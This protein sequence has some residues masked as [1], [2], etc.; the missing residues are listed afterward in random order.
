MPRLDERCERGSRVDRESLQTHMTDPMDSDRGPH[1][2]QHHGGQ[3]YSE[4]PVLDDQTTAGILHS[5]TYGRG[6]PGEETGAGVARTMV[7]AY[8]KWLQYINYEQRNAIMHV[9]AA[10]HALGIRILKAMRRWRGEAEEASKLIRLAQYAHLRRWG[11]RASLRRW[12][13]DAQK[14]K[15]RARAVAALAER[16]RTVPRMPRVRTRASAMTPI[17]SPV[18][19]GL[20][21][22]VD[23][24]GERVDES[25]TQRNLVEENVA[26]KVKQMRIEMEGRL[27]IAESSMR[28]STGRTIK[29]AVDKCEKLVGSTE[30]RSSFESRLEQVMQRIEAIEEAVQN[31]RNGVRKSRRSRSKSPSRSRSSSREASASE[32]SAG[33]V[34]TPSTSGMRTVRRVRI[35]TGALPVRDDDASSI[36]SATSSRAAASA[37]GLKDLSGSEIEQYKCDMTAK[38]IDERLV[39]FEDDMRQRHPLLDELLECTS[40]EYED[41]MIDPER[42]DLR[43]V[44][45]WLGRTCRQLVKQGGDDAAVFKC[46]E[47]QVRESDR[48][49]YYSGKRTLARMVD[50]HSLTSTKKVLAHEQMLKDKVYLDAS[51]NEMTAKR[52]CAAICDDWR[53]LPLTKRSTDKHALVRLLISKI[54]ASIREG[55]EK[56]LRE[57]LETELEE[58]EMKERWEGH[59]ERTSGKGLRWRGGAGTGRGRGRVAT[60]DVGAA[61]YTRDQLIELIVSRV[62]RKDGG[63]NVNFANGQK[64]CFNCGSKQCNLGM[65]KCDQLGKCRIKGCPCVRSKPCPCDMDQL[66]PRE[67]IESGEPGRSVTPHVYNKIERKWKAKHPSTPKGGA[68]PMSATSDEANKSTPAGAPA[69]ATSA[70]GIVGVTSSLVG[71][72]VCCVR[73]QK[74]QGVQAEREAEGQSVL[75]VSAPVFDPR[76]S[77]RSPVSVMAP[78]EAAREFAMRMSSVCDGAVVQLSSGESL[79]AE[80]VRS[81]QEGAALSGGESPMNAIS[82][83]CQRVQQI[84]EERK[85]ADEGGADVVCALHMRPAERFEEA[86]MVEMLLDTGADC[87]LTVTDLAREFAVQNDGR[88]EN[89]EGV[90]AI[91]ATA[92]RNKFYATLVGSHI[93]FEHVAHDMASSTLDGVSINVMSHS[94]LRAA[95]DVV[96]RYEPELLVMSE[97]MGAAPIEPRS[98]VYWIRVA[99]A[100]T[101][102]AAESAAVRF[103]MSHVASLRSRVGDRRHLLAARYGVDAEQLVQL[104]KAVLGIDVQRVPKETVIMINNDEALRRA[105]HRRP[106]SRAERPA[107]GLLLRAPGEVFQCDDVPSSI[108][109]IITGAWLT[110]E[111]TCE[112][113]GYGYG[114]PSG[115]HGEQE[116]GDFFEMI[117]IAEANLGHEVKM[118]KVDAARGPGGEHARVRLQMRLK[119]LVVPAAG[120]DH[121][122]IGAR[123][124][125][126]A[127]LTR[128]TEAA[129]LRAKSAVPPVPDGLMIKCRMYQLAILNDVPKAGESVSRRQVHTNLP[130]DARV[131]PRPLFWT[132]CSITAIGQQRGVKGLMSETRSSRERTGRVVGAESHLL[133]LLACDTK[134]V[135]TRDPEDLDVLDE[136]VL[137]AA[138]IPA[139]GAVKE[140][141]VQCE[142]EQ[143]APLVL[144]APAQGRAAAPPRPVVQHV[145]PGGEL[146]TVGRKLQVLWQ[147]A[148]G[149]AWH[150]HNAEVIEVSGEA[151][152]L[153][154]EGWE[155]RDKRVWHN[156]ARDHATAKHPWRVRHVRSTDESHASS[157]EHE[158]IPTA[159]DAQQGG[160]ITRARARAH[161][162]HVVNM[163]DDVVAA[164]TVE[165]PGRAERVWDAS[166]H[167]AFGEQAEGLTVA[168][169]GSLTRAR[170]QA[171]KLA[172]AE[173]PATQEPA[174]LVHAVVSAV[175]GHGPD[176]EIESENG[177]ARVMRVPRTDEQLLS[178]PDSTEWLIAERSAFFDSILPMPGNMLVSEGDVPAGVKI[179]HLVTVRRYK[180]QDK[181]LLKRKVRHS[182]DNKRVLRTASPEEREAMEQYAAYTMP[183]G[184]ME[185][186]IFLASVEPHHKLFLIDWTDAYGM[187]DNSHRNGEGAPLYVYPPRVLDVRTE[188]GA[189]AVLR[190]VSSLW[191]EGAAGNDF[192]VVRD[193]DLRACGWP[194]ISDVPAAYHSGDDR[195][196]VIMD[197]LLLRVTDADRVVKLAT[198]LS[199]RCMARG[200]KPVTVSSNPQ[201]WGGMKL[202]RDQACITLTSSLPERVHTSAVKW[203]PLLAETGIVP[204]DLPQGV[205]L[206]KLL[207]SLQL[208]RPR[209]AR[210]CKTTKNL[211]SLVGELK[212]IARRVIRITKHCHMLSC[213]VNAPQNPEDAM[214]AALGTLA[215][216]FLYKNEGRT[217]GG[218]EGQTAFLGAL[219]GTVSAA[220][221]SMIKRVDGGSKQ[222]APVQIE[223]ATDTTWNRL[224]E[225][226][227][228]H[229]EDIV[230]ADVYTHAITI[231]GALVHLELKR[232]HVVTGSSAELEGMGLLKLSDSTIW[233]R[234]VASRFGIKLNGPTLLMCDAEASLRTAAGRQASARLRHALRR[235]AIVTQRVRASEV[236]LAHLP[237]AANFVDMFTKWLGADK[238]ERSIAYLTGALQRAMYL[239]NRANTTGAFVAA[240]SSMAA[241]LEAL[242]M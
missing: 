238:V 30:G 165:E 144:A 201:K 9:D 121:E 75:R 81:T 155:G 150:W 54:P 21:R 44:D 196:V 209:P 134:Q 159:D 5:G 153:E 24:L 64:N 101:R 130:P 128:R 53:K 78:D 55:A 123:E 43:A 105:R 32:E 241:A 161:V 224:D 171:Y 93:G 156:L 47:R 176:V 213:I 232:A 191:G 90:G 182:Y 158:A 77:V 19:V 140:V 141:E 20:Q 187:G 66:P 118:F 172:S 56:S 12:C 164:F 222:S 85:S 60:P 136:H 120:D 189:K 98:S 122:F 242:E 185:A 3:D 89:I 111:A 237:D 225:S 114:I 168:A 26:S 129:M 199:E 34:E 117:K 184:E 50:H 100:K 31:M 80:S 148:S 88:T 132:R 186:N 63:G 58:F 229:G 139:A 166:L 69:S 68:A 219:K 18:L 110:L 51:M 119:V 103:Q 169:C 84:D 190:L 76:S 200:G 87:S 218:S 113:S 230:S 38:Q 195:A 124:G 83:A 45:T 59:R 95:A 233:A 10:T 7:D 142:L 206:T 179:A 86:L 46:D 160:P 15:E 138:G 49:A 236:E 1:A 65:A 211:M 72:L 99:L 207:D 42:D 173:S 192:E 143:R 215:L 13:K 194:A 67:R 35:E 2:S 154:Y 135:L 239:D 177:E 71:R 25:L 96:I 137:L 217:W 29:D 188:T 157:G 214:Q 212:W 131:K 180:T 223:G 28:E 127:P 104:S 163:V 167:S 116:W 97:A 175:T 115:A 94:Q 106:A 149:T 14:A 73:V 235:A 27:A 147:D 198:A 216:A 221:G 48:E 228:E 197:D 6:A 234:I 33:E 39:D 151:Q 202:E 181:Q 220:K 227:L 112:R 178:A 102:S 193:N 4:E 62:A 70:S 170:I 204:K 210:P 208:M 146:P 240:L 79:R 126:T 8:G 17:A 74:R 40:E 41:L 174:G 23:A 82:Q 231:N 92:G 11:E 107:K 109:C 125:T 91:T 205:K 36:A 226:A 61:W 57:R 145:V 133:E 162:K 183:V 22:K 37:Y 16:Q 203:L 108:Q 52:A 152:R